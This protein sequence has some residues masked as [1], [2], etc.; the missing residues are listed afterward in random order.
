MYREL[1]SWL[2][3]VPLTS[4][5]RC[6]LWFSIPVIDLW[7]REASH[8]T[9]YWQRLCSE[10]VVMLPM[11]YGILNEV[12][13]LPERSRAQSQFHFGL[14]LF[15]PVEQPSSLLEGHRRNCRKFDNNTKNYFLRREVNKNVKIVL[16][17]KQKTE[18]YWNTLLLTFVY[19][20]PNM[21]T[22]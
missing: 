13:L 8:T 16:S 10:P 18:N 4:V 11:F 22:P 3:S 2:S 1:K 7:E 9:Y 14:M 5:T 20:W 12:L 19:F 21:N 6:N 15:H 17:Q